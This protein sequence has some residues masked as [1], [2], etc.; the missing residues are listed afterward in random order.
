M[1]QSAQQGIY[2]QQPPVGYGYGAGGQ[3]RPGPTMTG[4]MGAPSQMGMAPGMPPLM[5]LAS[6][7]WAAVPG[8]PLLVAHTVGCAVCAEFIRHYMAAANDAAFIEAQTTVQGELQARFW[9][10]FEEHAR[11]EGGRAREEAERVAQ[12]LATANARIE[13]LEAAREREQARNRRQ[14]AEDRELWERYRSE[15]NTARERVNELEDERRQ[16]MRQMESIRPSSALT[17]V[18]HGSGSSGYIQRDPR[19]MSPRRDRQ[20]SGH[21]RIRTPPR[22]TQDDRHDDYPQAGRSSDVLDKFTAFSD[23]SDE[24]EVYDVDRIRKVSDR[25]RVRHARRDQPPPPAPGTGPAF[26]MNGPHAPT[27]RIPDGWPSNMLTVPG[28]SD[29]RLAS[30]WYNFVPVTTEDARM[31]MSASHADMGEARHRIQHLLAQIAAN[32]ALTGVQGLRVLNEHWRNPDRR[33][34]PL[35][36]APAR[37]YGRRGSP[38]YTPPGLVPTSTAHLPPPSRTWT[39][40][41]KPRINQPRLA[42]AVSRW[43]EWLSLHQSRIPAWMERVDGTMDGAPRAENV[44]LHLMIRRPVGRGVSVDDRGRWISLSQELF[45]VQ[46]L[47]R[48]IVQRGNYPRQPVYSPDARFAGSYRE[49]ELTLFHVARWYASAGVGYDLADRVQVSAWR[50]RALFHGRDYAET[51]Y[52][53]PGVNAVADVPAV[54]NLFELQTAHA[55]I[56]PTTAFLATPAPPAPI[57]GLPVGNA[58]EPQDTEMTDGPAAGSSDQGLAGGGVV[59][60][61]SPA[62]TGGSQSSASTPLANAGDPASS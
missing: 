27:I 50:A 21:G 60:G 2:L 53:F 34:A 13:E 54:P 6:L 48:H 28:E 52:V 39:E 40:P 26:T 43:I 7:S 10:H 41:A 23:E 19:E 38:Q 35:G 46:G 59:A 36:T 4:A 14:T 62:V 1:G 5:P 22:R 31:L 56:P 37:S 32:P 12:E 44:E 30:H 42:D 55:L 24:D 9:R 8:H 61:T 18:T 25:Q 49:G 58:P 33:S 29:A 47:Y 17:S 45:S 11:S 15:R 16:M 20:D 57:L 51:Q 3:F